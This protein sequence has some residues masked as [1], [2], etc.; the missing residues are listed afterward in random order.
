[1]GGRI[2]PLERGRG[3]L[4]HA[5]DDHGHRLRPVRKPPLEGVD[6]MAKRHACLRHREVGERLVAKVL[7]GQ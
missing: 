6:R 2:T 1:M 7:V 4:A 3:C 5:V